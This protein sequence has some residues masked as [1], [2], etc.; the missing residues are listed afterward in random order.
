MT[1]TT[2]ADAGQQ[3]A[4]RLAARDYPDPVVLALRR[5]GV[6]VAAAIADRL[7][8]PLDLVMARRSASPGRRRSL[9]G[10]R[11]SRRPAHRGHSA[12]PRRHRAHRGR[13]RGTRARQLAESADAA[14]GS[15]QDVSRSRSAGAPRRGRRR[16]GHRRHD[17]GRVQAVRRRGPAR[18]VLAVPVAAADTL[19]EPGGGGRRVGLS[20]DAASFP[21]G[22]GDL[23]RLPSGSDD[24]V[25]LLLAG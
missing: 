23:Q 7:H 20:A 8:A 17:A 18:I 22:G 3:L 5:A 21:G 16:R 15:W 24:E 25:K 1:F 6:P 12:G 2:R 9:R 13:R 10:G 19:G 4:A 14:R 11:R